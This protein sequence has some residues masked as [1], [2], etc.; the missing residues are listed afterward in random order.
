MLHAIINKIVNGI[1]KEKKREIFNNWINIDTIPKQNFF[2]EN[3]KILLGSL[4][5]FLLIV[6]GFINYSIVLRKQVRKKTIQLNEELQAKN[7]AIIQSGKNEARLE[8]LFELS[9]VK[10]DK[11]SVFLDYALAE[12]VRLTES[13]LGLLYEYDSSNEKFLL[14]NKAFT[15][16]DKTEDFGVHQIFLGK[17]LGEC[18]KGIFDNPG[19][20]L[21]ACHTCN[22]FHKG[23]C[24]LINAGTDNTL[25]FPII[26]EERLDL[27]YLANDKPYEKADAQQVVL[28][29]NAVWKLLSKQKWQ[30]E[31]IIAK[32]KAE[33][34]DKLK[35]AFL[36]NLSHEI[37]TPMNGIVGFS[38]LLKDSKISEQQ[39]QEYVRFIHTSTHYLL[40]VITDIIEISKIDSGIIQP[41]NNSFDIDQ[42][43]HAVY[44]ETL[45]TL[46]SGKDLKIIV[47]KKGAVDSLIITDDVKLKQ[48][49][50]NLV[51][52]AVKYTDEGFVK[53]EYGINQDN[54]LEIK[55]SDSG[56]G[57]DKKYHEIIF[58]RFRQG[59]KQLAILKGGTGLGLSISASYVKMM[60]GVIQLD[61]ELG[62][63]AVFTV[64]IPVQTAERKKE[65]KSKEELPVKGSG[66]KILI[67]E[68]NPANYYFLQELF[69]G[70]DFVLIHAKD[71]KEA[72]ELFNLHPDLDIILLDI[73][74]PQLDGYQVIKRI[75][76]TNRLIPVIAQTA[77]ALSDDHRKIREDRK[78]VV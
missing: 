73:K 61:S 17:A 33:E 39:R 21:N 45:N 76:E 49:I 66:I 23:V 64:R 13:K 74:M 31:L 47:E 56:P 3:Y 63:G 16:E 14:S 50:L 32:A 2:Q 71:G 44:M 75:R 4:I 24:P 78:S 37:R 42:L 5:F 28:L 36:A 62:K 30:E 22:L 55:V 19:L 65:E 29:I 77:Y 52:N 41:N 6:F 46:N 69:R 60:G 26:E 53:I 7:Q 1:S 11:S 43:I 27:L 15:G 35:S 34:S 68:D 59:D 67:A 70:S 25:I 12:I 57:I 9:K 8:S 54:I 18:R 58:E 20:L 38:E 48:V 51:S 72:L 10:T 40:S